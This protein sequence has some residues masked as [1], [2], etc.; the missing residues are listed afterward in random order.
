[1]YMFLYLEFGLGPCV[2]S[3]L[4]SIEIRR[5]T[6]RLY[7]SFVTLVFHPQPTFFILG[8]NHYWSTIFCVDSKFGTYLS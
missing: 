4:R 6:P 2:M 1:M 7:S 8:S 5:I 3:I